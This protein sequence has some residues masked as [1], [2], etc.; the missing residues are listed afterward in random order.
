MSAL[1][2]VETPA[3]APKKS[4]FAPD[5]FKPEMARLKVDEYLEEVACQV[6]VDPTNRNIPSM[7]SLGYRMASLGPLTLSNYFLPET[8]RRPFSKGIDATT[9]NAVVESNLRRL[10]RCKAMARMLKQQLVMSEFVAVGVKAVT[11]EENH[12]RVGL[13]GKP[14]QPLNGYCSTCTGP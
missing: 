10:D 6:L 1:G 12:N 3:T 7:V 5:A 14:W 13:A 8:A 9:A 2:K 11:G 4:W